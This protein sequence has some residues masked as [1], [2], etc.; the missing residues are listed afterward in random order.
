M[1]WRE[2]PQGELYR[3]LFAL[4]KQHPALWNAAWGA[5]MVRVPHDGEDRV[6]GFVRVH[7]SGDAVVAAFN[8]SDA[9]AS[10]TL[11]VA[12]GQDLAYVD[13]TDGSTVEYAE[14]SVWQLPARGYRVGVTPQE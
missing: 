12:P 4:K 2:D 3:R 5:R 10:V 6:I 9:P 7:E 1:V 8:L 14:G 13:A 11:G